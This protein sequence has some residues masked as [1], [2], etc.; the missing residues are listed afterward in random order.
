MTP[1]DTPAPP[2]IRHGSCTALFVF[3]VALS[4]DLDAAE[5]TLRTPKPLPAGVA[6]ATGPERE[7][8]KP[9]ISPVGGYVR[10]VPAYFE[11][12]PSPIRFTLSGRPISAG[13]MLSNGRTF[14]T[15][16]EV[17]LLLFDFGAVC[18]SYRFGLDGASLG[19]LLELSEHLFDFHDLAADA[20]WHVDHLAATIAAA[21]TKPGVTPQV[22]DY[23]LYE[24]RD[25]AT[26]AQAPAI[27]PS[28]LIAR[29][30]R[31]LAQILRA[32]RDALSDE[33]IADALNCRV[34]YGARD[35]AIID[36][37]AA[38]LLDRDAEDVRSVLEF[39]NVELLE[40]R[41]LD[42]RLD[43]I[44]EEAYRTVG[45]SRVGLRA[46]FP[47]AS[48]ELRR[49]AKLQMDSALLFEGVNNALKLIGD[50]YLARVYR[51][52]ANRFHLPE[53]D[54]IIERKLSTLQSIYD[55][56]NDH[57]AGRR[58]SVL[59]WIIILLILFEVVMGLLTLR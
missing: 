40:M 15:L 30:G 47:L 1:A 27:V 53:R 39:A 59:E 36:W 26:D 46:L 38:I 48:R 51:V 16:P 13:A 42:D 25:V 35:A 57:E 5:A 9:P 43:E 10:K 14:T 4:I 28:E 37:N 45:K 23:L 44:L 32:E 33:E 54:Q 3:D 11:Y 41:F 50:Q 24:L 34:A 12:R 31:L 21:L 17:E 2:L 52:A 49:M 56:L 8:L 55:K 58:A 18:V 7:T 29:H 22:E 19:D 6:G 20:R